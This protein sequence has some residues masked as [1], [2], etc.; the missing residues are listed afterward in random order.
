M[1]YGT[2]RD[3]QVRQKAMDLVVDVYQSTR[4]FPAEE[5]FGLTAQMRRSAVSIPSNIAE[6]HGRQSGKEFSRFLWIANGSATELETQLL[7]AHRLEM[8]TEE[9]HQRLREN[10]RQIGRMLAGLRTSIEQL[11]P[12]IPRN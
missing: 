5:R 7:I 8:I 3:L 2:Y 6:G 11:S 4:E 12:N 10:L 9:N 1:A